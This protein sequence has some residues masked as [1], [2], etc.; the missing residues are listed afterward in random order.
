MFSICIIFLT[1][2]DGNIALNTASLS[3]VKRSNARCVNVR[4]GAATHWLAHSLT[5]LNLL[6]VAGVV[7]PD[8]LQVRMQSLLRL[9]RLALRAQ[10]RR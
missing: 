5:W 10:T 4:V 6:D 1:R 7:S 3:A 8:L 9:L 2:A